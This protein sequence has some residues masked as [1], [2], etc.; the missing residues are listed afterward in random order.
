MKKTFVSKFRFLYNSTYLILASVIGIL[1][2]IGFDYRIFY[3][4]IPLLLF[5][6]VASFYRVR[7]AAFGIFF[8]L[9][10]LV[11]F[12]NQYL[13]SRPDANL[14]CMEG[15]VASSQKKFKTKSIYKIKSVKPILL[16]AQEDLLFGDIVKI[17]LDKKIILNS[18]D[19]NYLLSQFKLN[20]V[21]EASELN[22][23]RSKRSLSRVINVLSTNIKARSAKLFSSDTGVLAYG[24]LFGS[25][26][27][28]SSDFKAA[29]KRSGTSHI[30]AVSGYNVSLITTWLFDGLRSIGKNFAGVFSVIILIIFYL[31]T[32]GSASVL[33]ASIMGVIV[34]ISKFIGRRVSPFHLLILAA[35]I[36]LFMNPF[37]IYDWGF[38]LSFMATAGLFF[39]SPLLDQFLKKLPFNQALKKIFSETLSAQVFV[40]PILINNF[41]SFSLISPLT[42]LL[43]L[44]FIPAA[45]LLVFIT[46]SVS[47][48]SSVFAV[49]MSLIAKIV[50]S[51]IMLVVGSSSE[52]PFAA[53]NFKYSGYVFIVGSYAVIFG[54]VFL[55]K[56]RYPDEKQDI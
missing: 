38:Q 42:N 54:L 18:S 47:A 29:L 44:P 56:K 32:G 33:R 13:I 52:I 31:M 39:L 46:F 5:S 25:T 1:L 41:G 17:C 55:F 45:M 43:I 48:V 37:S 14:G 8:S 2:G 12:Y 35:A 28:F 30:V 10:I 27:D 16:V 49:F 4:L 50:L 26:S 24:L 15:E 34:L 21:Y 19:N 11:G 22:V 36:I 7:I 53:V 40:L 51:Y 9:G 3:L 6:L 23:I 20:N